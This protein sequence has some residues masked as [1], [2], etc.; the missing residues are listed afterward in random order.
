[1]T[2]NLLKLILCLTLIT[3]FACSKSQTMQCTEDN[4]IKSNFI[5]DS[6]KMTNKQRNIISVFTKD[7]WNKKY[8]NTNFSYQEIFTD[9][10]YCNICCNSSS[11]KIIS[12]SG[13]EYLF[14][15]SLSISTFSRELINLIGSMSIGSKENEKLRD[16]LGMRK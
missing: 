10:F 16:T 6:N 2:K 14:D 9:F 1:M 4:Y 8:Q 3:S 7:D 11:N 13:K 15:N 5:N 12:Y